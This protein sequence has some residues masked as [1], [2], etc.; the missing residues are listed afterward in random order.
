NF[1][2]SDWYGKF[3]K[4][5]SEFIFSR[6]RETCQNRENVQWLFCK[7]REHMKELILKIFGM[8]INPRILDLQYLLMENLLCNQSGR[9]LD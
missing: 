4:C 5:S 7:N 2:K 3:T 1:D 9:Q 6:I 8:K